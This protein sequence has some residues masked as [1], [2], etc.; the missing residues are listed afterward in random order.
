MAKCPCCGQELNENQIFCLNCMT[1]SITQKEINPPKSKIKSIESNIIF[2][3][4]IVLVLIAAIV[5]MFFATKKM[6]EI[7]KEYTQAGSSVSA[8]NNIKNQ[9]F[10]INKL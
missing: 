2:R 7:V 8:G 6:T 5:Y 1:K 3:V 9:G 10:C 4:I